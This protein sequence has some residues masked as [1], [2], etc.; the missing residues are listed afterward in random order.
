MTC[1]G[2]HLESLALSLGMRNG[3]WAPKQG[4]EPRSGGRRLLGRVDGQWCTMGQAIQYL[5]F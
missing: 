5:L 2:S 4:R 3:L 1:T